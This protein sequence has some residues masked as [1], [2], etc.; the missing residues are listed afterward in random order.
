MAWAEERAKQKWSGLYRDAGGAKRR[1][2]GTYAT[3]SLAKD[4]ATAAEVAANSHKGRM[5]TGPSPTW[6]QW[7]ER[8]WAS[9]AVEPS[10]IQN[11][12]SMVKKHII[13]RW[14]DVKIDEIRRLDVQAWVSDLPLA[15]E[16]ARRVLGVLV[17]SL[18]A[19]VEEGVLD[20]NPAHRIKL[21]PRPQGRE[22]FLSKDQFAALAQAIPSH[23]DRAVVKLL[24]GTGM[25]WGEL[26]G[27]H[28]RSVDLAKGAVT[29]RDV[30]SAGEI[31][32]YPK[33]RKQRHVP[34]FDWVVEDLDDTASHV[35]CNAEH[36]DAICASGLVFHNSAG[37]PLN[38]RNFYRRVLLPALKEAKLDGLGVTLH[39]LR[40]TYASWLA[41]SGVPL[42]RIAELLGHASISTTQIYAH[43]MPARHD[44]LARAL[45]ANWGQTST[46]NDS[47]P[48]LRAVENP[49]PRAQNA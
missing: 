4:A 48:L 38:D 25:R 27:L 10:T 40:H 9:R 28:W 17:S 33:G 37:M 45:G 18:S 26:A 2:P 32:P 29:V 39:D 41:Q 1:L 30:Y 42:E 15:Q 14:A 19:A 47:R 20:T 22:V 7:C 36:R 8:W 16:S 21:P 44:D 31:K 11:E 3:K 13:P 46:S 5:R 6:G 43:L 35:V 24:A 49:K 23:N 34:L 12:D